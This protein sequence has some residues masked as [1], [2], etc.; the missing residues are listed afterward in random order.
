MYNN[1]IR[2]PPCGLR[3]CTHTMRG[4]YG[5]THAGCTYTLLYHAASRLC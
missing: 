5:E 4:S 1:L 2:N 3:R